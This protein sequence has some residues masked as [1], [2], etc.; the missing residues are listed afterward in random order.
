M[1]GRIAYFLTLP[2]LILILKKRLTTRVFIVHNGQVLVLKNWL[3]SG[4]YG[5]PGGGIKALESPNQALLR[6]VLE[7]TNIKLFL[8]DL[9][10][11]GLFQAKNGSVKYSYHLWT[12]N[13]DKKVKITKQFFEITSWNWLDLNNLK[14]NYLT[15]EV[16]KGLEVWQ[17]NNESVTII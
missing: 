9:K 7:E 12:V 17:K 11:Q 1:I 15:E 5:L 4:R 10:Y 3:S 6:E 2:A 16:L 8:A 14:D 13:L